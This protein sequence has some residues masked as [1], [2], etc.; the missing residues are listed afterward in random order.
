MASSI[1]V[2]KYIYD[3]F[4][5]LFPLTLY[6]STNAALRSEAGSRDSF[7]ASRCLSP[8]S[9]IL[10]RQPSANPPP[11]S[12]CSHSTTISNSY[13]PPNL[14]LY[15]KTKQSP[16]TRDIV[17][18][19]PFSSFQHHKPLS[20]RQKSSS[21]NY[22]YTYISSTQSDTKFPPTSPSTNY[23]TA[24]PPQPPQNQYSSSPPRPSPLPVTRGV[25]M[26]SDIHIY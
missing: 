9:L 21:Y 19:P 5:F 10:P 24:P 11:S 16:L 3:R 1:F 8:L 15:L 4:S 23:T 20:T 12:T 25:V 7:I 13:L 18:H 2:W 26:M 22:Y 6:F 14:S 17:P